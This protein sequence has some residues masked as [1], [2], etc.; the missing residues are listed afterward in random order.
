M[1]ARACAATLAILL[2]T[3]SH[4]AAQIAISAVVT[5]VMQVATHAHPETIT[6]SA[7]DV[8]RGYVDIAPGPTLQVTTNCRDGVRIAFFV[9]GDVVRAVELR[10]AGS[11]LALPGVARGAV[12]HRVPLLYRLVLS[13][14]A[15]PGVHAWPVQ[16]VATPL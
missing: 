16:L 8:A 14:G 2:P 5:K 4:S 11:V 7:E 12:T 10:G 13:A 1:L 3:P 9:F 6:V 15:R